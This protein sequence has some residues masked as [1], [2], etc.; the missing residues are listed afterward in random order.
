MW[1][2]GV[3]ANR[4]LN[5]I[6]YIIMCIFKRIITIMI[7]FHIMLT[8]L[9]NIFISQLYVQLIN[10]IIMCAN[11]PNMVYCTHYD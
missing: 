5:N 8:P 9:K 7:V 11:K 10:R 1:I 4:A 3:V 6:Y 2:R